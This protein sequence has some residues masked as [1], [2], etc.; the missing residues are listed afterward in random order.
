MNRKLF[1]LCCVFL[2]FCFAQPSLFAFKPKSKYFASVEAADHYLAVRYNL[3]CKHYNQGDWDGALPHFKMVIFYF[4]TSDEAALAHYYLG[5]CYYQ[6][7]EYDLASESFTNYLKTTKHPE[8]FEG[9]IQYKFCIAEL[10]KAGQKRRAFTIRTLPKCMNA[11][12][13]ALENYD[14]IIAALPSKPITIKAL[15]SKGEL[16]MKMKEYKDAIETF[17]IIIRKFPKNGK[18]PECYLKIAN[19]YVE[20]SIIESQNPDILGLAELNVRKF[21]EDFPREEHLSQAEDSIQQIREAL[22][23]GLCNIGL[24]YERK[25]LYN[26]AVIYFK[27]AIEDYPETCVAQFCQCKVRQLES[28]TINPV[29]EK[30]ESDDDNFEENDDE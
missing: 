15:F 13:T 16:L 18:V 9:V 7:R 20:Q 2:G 24:F 3:G 19:C 11:Y 27:C 6:L 23:R 22:A 17:Q 5:V 4:P 12:D 30:N 21:K 1:V 28:Q 8:F 14:E 26:A 25:E 10:F 29:S